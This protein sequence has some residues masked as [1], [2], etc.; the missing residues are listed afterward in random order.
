MRYNL[1]KKAIA[2]LTAICLLL[3]LYGCSSTTSTSPTSLS[4]QILEKT[5][6][7]ELKEL[8]GT[9]LPSYFVFQDTSVKRFNVKVSATGKSA[10]TIACF[11]VKDSDQRSKVVSGISQYLNKL[12]TSFKTTME[13]EYQKVQNRL[14]LEFNNIIVLVVCNDYT[15]VTEFLSEFGA[16]EIF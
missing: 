12:S 16:K 14:L 5:T 4:E 8:S 3:S 6:F 13:M 15:A 11:E 2:L 10:D 9:S 1:L 7:S